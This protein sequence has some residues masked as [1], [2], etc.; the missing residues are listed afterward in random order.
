MKCLSFKDV[1]VFLYDW[2][3]A[4]SHIAYIITKLFRVVLQNQYEKNYHQIKSFHW[5]L[6][7]WQAAYQKGGLLTI[8]CVGEEWTN[9]RVYGTVAQ[10]VGEK[11]EILW[12]IDDE[13][14]VFGSDHL[15]IDDVHGHQSVMLQLSAYLLEFRV[16]C[17]SWFVIIALVAIPL[18]RELHLY[19]ISP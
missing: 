16:K 14:S 10:Q 9:A 7:L 8:H 12:D 6:A 18:K 5:S 15:C 3:S 1:C 4:F 13:R 11:F 17:V 2:K 19:K